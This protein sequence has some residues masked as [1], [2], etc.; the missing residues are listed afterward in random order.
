[1]RRV[2]WWGLVSSAAAPLLLIGGWTVAAAV[3]P[4]PFD[5]VVRTISDLAARDAS[6]RWLMT[7][8]LI[9]VGVSHLVTAGA[10][11][12]A[13]ARG[14]LVLAFGGLATILVAVFPLPGGG[15]SSTP[16][17]VVAALAFV[18]L[19]I[20]PAFARVR[21]SAP[22]R[23]VAVLLR[24]RASAGAAGVLMLLLGWF[25]AEQVIGGPAVGLA[26]RV[27]AGA[28]SVWPLAVVL[29]AR[30]LQSGVS[31]ARQVRGRPAPG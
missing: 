2:P 25:F 21:P 18:S 15:Q 17:T 9:G 23:T 22:G 26:E 31:R 20:W 28:Q 1:M 19:A 24:P 14:R 16:H 3:Q 29:S 4:V 11:G 8:A 12:C 7:T 10:L 27:A 6:Q 30:L 13:A 5:S